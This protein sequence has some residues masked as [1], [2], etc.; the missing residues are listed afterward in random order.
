[1]LNKYLYI[2]SHALQRSIER[3][4][5][6]DNLK[7]LLESKESRATFQRNGRI[8]IENDEIVAIIQIEGDDLVLIT[9]FKNS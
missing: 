2:R 3:E 9:A 4:I 1:M 6:L 5:G 8:R 7:S